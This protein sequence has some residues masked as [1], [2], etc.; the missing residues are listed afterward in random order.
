M[1]R[2]THC[3]NLSFDVDSDLS[4]DDLERN[5]IPVEDLLAAIQKRVADLFLQNDTEPEIY[6]AIG[7]PD[8]T[9]DNGGEL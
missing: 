3:Y 6:E 9:I 1:K 5:N 7:L 4:P 8:D 2:Y